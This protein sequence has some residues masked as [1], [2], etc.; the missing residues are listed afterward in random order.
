MLS[1]TE[2]FPPQTVQCSG[3]MIQHLNSL[4]PETDKLRHCGPAGATFSEHNL[5][6]SVGPQWLNFYQFSNAGL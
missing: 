6:K 4:T 3:F 1:E 2:G 5:R